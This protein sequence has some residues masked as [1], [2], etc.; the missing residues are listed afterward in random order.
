[1]AGVNDFISQALQEGHDINDI[2]DYT[3]GSDD[4]EFKNWGQTWKQNASQPAYQPGAGIVQQTA[5]SPQQTASDANQVP[6]STGLLDFANQHPVATGALALGAAT[7]AHLLN[8]G[9]IEPWAIGK[10]AEAEAKAQSKY[11][12][13]GVLVQQDQNQIKL[14]EL[15]LERQKLNMSQGQYDPLENIRLQREQAALEKDQAV[16]EKERANVEHLRAKTKAIADKADREQ[17]MAEERAAAAKNAPQKSEPV[18]TAPVVPQT[19]KTVE[20]QLI[21][22]KT[23]ELGLPPSVPAGNPKVTAGE[24][25]SIVNSEANKQANAQPAK[26]KKEP[27]NKVPEGHVFKEGIGPG[28]NWLYNTHGAEGRK[29]IL[30]EFNE[31]KP[32]GSYEAALELNKKAQAKSIGPAIPREVALNRGIQPPETNF[33]KLGKAAK[34]GGV[35]GL[36]IAAAD[37]ANAKT[38]QERK[39]AKSVLGEMM[40]PLGAIPFGLNSNESEELAKRAKMPPTISR[41]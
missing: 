39:N 3:A 29:A 24:V 17:K 18:K 13:P 19:A 31:G 33:G 20:D 1:M 41:K 32:V 5:Q 8:K 36:L 9:V 23:A 27:V 14:Q 28:D 22:K 16:A 37:V 38:P 26:T 15:E 12:S 4:P 6:P 34:I 21:A 10:R 35:A 11:P 7:G 30:N 2:V 40:L 25:E